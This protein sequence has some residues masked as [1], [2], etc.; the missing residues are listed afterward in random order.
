[1]HYIVQELFEF[2]AS[3]VIRVKNLEDAI[4]VFSFTAQLESSDHS[5]ELINRDCIAGIS[6]EIVEDLPQDEFLSR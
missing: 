5:G 6:V 1:M 2:D 3:T 4:K